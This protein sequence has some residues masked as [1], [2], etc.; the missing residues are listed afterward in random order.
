MTENQLANPLPDSLSEAVALG[1]ILQEKR[2]RLKMEISEI[3]HHLKIK[4]NNI[5]AIENGDL[6][7]ITRYLCI[8]GLIRSYGKFLRINEK[9][10]EEKIKFLAI[11]T[12]S[13]GKKYRL[14]NIGEN[15]DLSPS[16]EVFLN[17]AMISILLFLLL[18]S[19]YN[20][21]ENKNGLITN[22]EIISK[23]ENTD[24]SNE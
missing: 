4:K 11:K 17:S 24:A 15:A 19:F 16:K 9:I 13:D 3:A 12:N 21:Y 10:I 23:L 5:E 1:K 2:E 6:S 7:S 20:F 8:H 14:V 22:Q 18:L